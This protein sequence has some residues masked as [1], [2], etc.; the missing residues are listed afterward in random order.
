[1]K[2]GVLAASLALSLMATPAAGGGSKAFLWER[3]AD[4]GVPRTEVAAAAMGDGRIVVAAGFTPTATTA[5][6]EIYDPGADSWSPGPPLPTPVNHAMAAASGGEVF[7]FGGYTS[8]GEPVNQ[9]LVLRGGSWETLPPMP[10]PR[11]AGGA[12]AAGAAVGAEHI[13]VVGGIGPS[14]LATTTLVFDPVGETWTVGPGLPHPRE[15]LAVAGDE[16]SV[17]AIGGRTAA[18][19]NL[20]T[21]DQLF[22]PEGAW[23]TMKDLPTPRSGLGAAS[24][25]NGFVIAAGGEGDR[26]FDEV[27]GW[28]PLGTGGHWM[29]L[30]AMPTGRHGLGVVAIENT[31]YTLHGGPQPGLAFSA[32]TEAIRVKGF[33]TLDCDL[34]ATVVGSPRRDVIEGGPGRDVLVGLGGDDALVGDGA[35]DRLCGGPGDDRLRGSAGNDRLWGGAGGDVLDGAGGRDLL[36]GGRGVD[37]CEIRP[38]PQPRSCELPRAR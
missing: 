2:R 33:F 6:V 21:A 11:A 37:R 10:E 36:Y 5:E 8:T 12:A 31:V 15:H 27:E 19:G 17:Y 28:W 7:V 3:L 29:R 9:A 25:A 38:K 26:I 32:R 14:G 30:P 34:P 13:Y 18:E 1:M 4:A 35:S 24:T 23:R 22:I 20:A 16:G